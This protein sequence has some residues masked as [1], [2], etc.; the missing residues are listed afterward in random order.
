MN[1]RLA[2]VLQ[3]LDTSDYYLERSLRGLAPHELTMRIA[4]A[5]SPLWI[6]GHVAIGRAR[7]AGFLG[8]PSPVPWVDVFGKG[9]CENAATVMPSVERVL[10]L[11]REV[12]TDV[13]ARL[14]SASEAELSEPG[15]P[16]LPGSDGT[17]LGT[18]VYLVFHEAYHVGQI[19]HARKAAGRGLARRT[20]DRLR[21][22]SE[23]PRE[24]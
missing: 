1:P 20:A 3:L 15:G 19:A 24:Q 8:S 17:R 13:R 5:N 2:G 14:A 7:L 10:A 6:A 4:P 22:P 23:G 21:G 16:E 11:W 9:A 18:I 12:G